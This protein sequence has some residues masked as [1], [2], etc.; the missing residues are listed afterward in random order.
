MH[1]I[2]LLYGFFIGLLGTFLGCYL[3]I[4]LF[5]EYTFL[6]GIQIIKLQGNLGKVI[7]LGTILDLIVFGLLLQF[8]RDLMARGVILAV[9]CV[10]I[11]TL[12]VK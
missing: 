11:F 12:F 7:T 10:T 4:I 6:A 1:K 8:K 3:F 2:D 9:I 5:T